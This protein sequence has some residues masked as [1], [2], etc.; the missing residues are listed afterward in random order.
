[1]KNK[2]LIIS[3]VI[4]AVVIIIGV[5][6]F[7]IYKNKKKQKEDAAMQMAILQQQLS[8][9]NMPATQ[10]QSILE[11]IAGLAVIIGSNLPT[12]QSPIPIGQTPMPAQANIPGAPPVET[13]APSDFPLKKNSSGL[14]VKAVQNAVNSKCSSKLKAIGMS[15]LV[16]DGKFGPLTEK[17]VAACLGTTTVSWEQ[18]KQLL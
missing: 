4:I 3:I 10:K 7:L 13:P 17:G 8:Q 1:M 6:G 15:P 11:Q 5:V 9:S 2:K 14:F 18:Y 16:A 12:K